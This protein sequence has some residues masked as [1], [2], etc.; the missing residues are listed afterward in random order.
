M[1]GDLKLAWLTVL[2]SRHWPM[3]TEK[4]ERAG[5]IAQCKVKT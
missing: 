4:C 2:A 1:L 5:P 3:R